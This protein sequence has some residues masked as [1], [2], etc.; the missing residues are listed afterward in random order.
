MCS[1]RTIPGVMLL[2][3]L[4]CLCFSFATFSGCNTGARSSNGTMIPNVNLSAPPLE[5]DSM[6]YVGPDL[7]TLRYGQTQTTLETGRVLVVGGTDEGF[8]TSIDTVE[9]FDQSLTA[10]P[11]PQSLG[12]DWVTT[13]LNGDPI[14]LVNGGRLSHTSTLLPNGNVLIAGGSEDHLI[15]EAHPEAEIFDIL[16]R[17]FNTDAVMPVNEMLEPRFRHT[18]TLLPNGKVAIV[19]GQVSMMVTIIDP[20]EPPGSPFFQFDITVFPSTK[21]VEVYNPAS[22]SF[23]SLTGLTGAET[24]LQTTRGRA[25]H[26]AVMIAGPD[27]RLET[28]DDILLVSAGYQT[29]SPLFAP[30][31]KFPGQPGLQPQ[32]VVEFLDVSTGIM[33]IAPGLSLSPGRANG[34]HMANLGLYGPNSTPA[35]LNPTDGDSCFIDRHLDE[36]IV[37]V[38]NTVIVFGGDDNLGNCA[39]SVGQTDL[40]ACTFTGFGIA[41]GIQFFQTTSNVVGLEAAFVAG[42]SAVGRTH[43]AHVTLPARRRIRCSDP[44]SP[45]FGTI[46]TTHDTVAPM[47]IGG[48][49]VYIPP[50]GGCAKSA[51]GLDCAFP[52]VSGIE[53]FSPWFVPILNDGN[54]DWFF[55]EPQSPDPPDDFIASWVFRPLNG[56]GDPTDFPDLPDFD[57]PWDLNL[58]QT[59]TL[60]PTGIVGTWL[61]SD[62]AYC[63]G[64]S[65]D[66]LVNEFAEGSNP[67]GALR[68]PRV[69]CSA[70]AIP[71]EDGILNTLDDR[72]L[73][74]GG[75]ADYYA[76]AVFGE[77]AVSIGCEVFL[78]PFANGLPTP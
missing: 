11:L 56:D 12:G 37:G 42:C 65:L 66:D 4:A 64:D 71:G 5:F 72:V 21:V 62:A 41:S 53:I 14:L 68:A 9:I 1:S 39:N 46:N 61:L 35:K 3:T 52:S 63:D 50:T 2:G 33:S 28:A 45:A 13:D 69:L 59:T 76:G 67:T 22:R 24:E 47:L 25:D 26:A 20:N 73:V 31:L 7:E 55:F 57:V 6:S 49:A 15:A 17:Q 51:F 75:A 38:N 32:Q 77:E 34:V 58:N 44:D 29:P 19:G 10:D 18:A 43:A 54:D 40:I 74:V 78:P 16:A 8:L 60:H 70:S 27:N 23:E 36:A 48:L 30:I